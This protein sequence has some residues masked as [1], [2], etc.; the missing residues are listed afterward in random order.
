VDKEEWEAWLENPI[1]RQV[2][3]LILDE[4]NAYLTSKQALN[5]RSF[6]D[7]H[8]FYADSLVLTARAESYLAM[9]ESLDVEAFEDIFEDKT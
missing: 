3:Q 7:A 4:H 1:T 2:R 9:Y 6:E 8:G 5:P